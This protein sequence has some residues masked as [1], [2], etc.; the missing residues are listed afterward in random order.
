MSVKLSKDLTV[1]GKSSKFKYLPALA[2]ILTIMA[3][4]WMTTTSIIGVGMLI[5]AISTPSLAQ[6]SYQPLQRGSVST[7]N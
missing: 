5:E 3:G 4:V 1:A 7:F 2:F 6:N